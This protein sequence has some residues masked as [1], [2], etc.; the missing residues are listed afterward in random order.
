MLMLAKIISACY[1]SGMQEL[2]VYL[3]DSG[4]L[5]RNAK[6]QYFIYAGYI[7]TS[8]SEKDKAL[9]R[10]YDAVCKIKRKTRGEIKA[11][12]VKPL[13]KSF[14]NDKMNRFESLSCVVDK[15]RVYDR[16]LD[17]SQSI[18]RYKDY[19][20]KLMAKAKILNLIERGLVDPNIDTIVHFY[21][22]EQPTTTDGRYSL[23]EG[24]FT[25]FSAGTQN[26]ATHTF[27]EPIFRRQCII[28]TEICDSKENYL[29]QAADFLANSIFI[30]NNRRKKSKRQYRRHTEIL[31]P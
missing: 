30:D 8:I 25:E 9:L 15:T 24:I 28:T 21:I 29:I 16:I 6:E 4:V 17:C 20:I 3:D 31:L 5:H 18:H 14:L 12:Q 26:F 27:Y 10:F 1:N 7:F 13:V 19:C 22:D 11:S 2:F 23:Q